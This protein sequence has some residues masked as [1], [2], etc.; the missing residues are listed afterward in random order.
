MFAIGDKVFFNYEGIIFPCKIKSVDIVRGNPIKDSHGHY[1]MRT[2]ELVC[3]IT[4]VLPNDETVTGNI[5][6]FSVGI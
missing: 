6:E 4:A 1:S 3:R 2:Y 5:G